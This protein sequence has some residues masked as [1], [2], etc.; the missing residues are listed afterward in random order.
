MFANSG[1]NVIVHQ[2]CCSSLRITLSK[3]QSF[4]I[5][6]HTISTGST[7]SLS[8]LVV[9]IASMA[10]S[11]VA[12]FGGLLAFL[13]GKLDLR[14]VNG[15]P[16]AKGDVIRYH[17]E[18]TE[19]LEL[20]D[21]HQRL[22]IGHQKSEI[23]QLKKTISLLAQIASPKHTDS[24]SIARSDTDLYGEL[25]RQLALITTARATPDSNTMSSINA[26]PSVPSRHDHA[27][28]D[29]GSLRS[30]RW[31]KDEGWVGCHVGEAAVDGLTAAVEMTRVADRNHDENQHTATSAIAEDA[32]AVSTSAAEPAHINSY[33]V[34]SRAVAD[35]HVDV[36][37]HPVH[38]HTTGDVAI[39]SPSISARVTIVA[40]TSAA[41]V[42]MDANSA[43]GGNNSTASA[44]ATA[45]GNGTGSAHKIARRPAPTSAAT[46]TGSGSGESKQPHSSSTLAAQ[47]LL[48]AR[49]T[50]S[51]RVASPGESAASAR[52]ATATEA[53]SSERDS[54]SPLQG[55][56]ANV[57]AQSGGSHQ[58]A[59]AESAAASSNAAMS[60]ASSTAV[61]RAPPPP[62]LA[63][64]QTV[65][66]PSP[67]D[68][69]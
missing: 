42:S 46:S 49:S 26:Q 10:G 24:T 12:V 14:S 21:E 7:T 57:D 16:H 55:V 5:V 2:H 11:L 69:Q 20:N 51:A 31:S 30:R 9:L 13:E 28:F 38:A 68:Q 32:H 39:A 27:N 41:N 48:R 8:N 18:R 43:T 56:G 61:K 35:V 36:D 29:D 67:S 45:T 1:C 59:S 53:L 66:T 34:N 47:A 44:T 15:A 50:V 6:S 3:S 60:P 40:S 37:P 62:P 25:H 17:S 22:E 64:K 54:R 19:Q 4:V 52:S 65:A 63:R 58:Q 23:A 33:S